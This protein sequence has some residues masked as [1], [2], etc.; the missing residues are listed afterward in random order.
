MIW[1]KNE[2]LSV[3]CFEK[4]TYILRIYIVLNGFSSLDKYPKY[5]I[6]KLRLLF[7]K[8]LNNKNPPPYVFLQNQDHNY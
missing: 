5:A 4:I 3:F 2:Y 6:I 1:V 8:S 7:F